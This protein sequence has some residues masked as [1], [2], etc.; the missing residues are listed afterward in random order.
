M[1]FDDFLHHSTRA[2]AAMKGR[3]SDP[4]AS[5]RAV[6]GNSEFAKERGFPGFLEEFEA[7][8]QKSRLPK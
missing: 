5:A 4:E 8:L 6:E 1:T 2:L 3:R 7:E